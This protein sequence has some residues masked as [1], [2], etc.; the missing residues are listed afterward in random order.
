MSCHCHLGK[1]IR[2]KRREKDTTASSKTTRGVSVREDPCKEEG[3][4]RRDHTL[5]FLTTWK[6]GKRRKK[7]RESS[8][9]GQ[10]A[11]RTPEP[12]DRTH[13]GRRE[14]EIG[15]RAGSD[16]LLRRSR[17]ETP[18]SKGESKPDLPSMSS[19]ERG[20]KN[21]TAVLLGRSGHWAPEGE[22]DIEGLNEIGS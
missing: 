22:A 1:G 13:N 8:H 14:R 9:L 18:Y 2:G 4:V 11:Q 6:N 20:T 16:R 19:V 17:R 21:D 12:R 15:L 5:H 7:V 10:G 3:A